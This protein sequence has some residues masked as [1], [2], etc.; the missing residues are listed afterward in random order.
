MKTPWN[1]KDVIQKQA[2]KEAEELWWENLQEGRLIEIKPA[3][4]HIPLT[5]GM[6]NL[7]RQM[8]P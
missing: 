3:K 6:W 5:A 1:I 7:I 4:E 8:A 2:N